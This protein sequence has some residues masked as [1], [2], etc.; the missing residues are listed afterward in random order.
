LHHDQEL[1]RCHGEIGSRLAGVIRQGPDVLARFAQ[2]EWALLLPHTGLDA[3]VAV[4]DRCL[5]RVAGHE[6]RLGGATVR[7]TVSAGVSCL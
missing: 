7:L 1:D 6:L 4:V 3:A 5:E 2:D